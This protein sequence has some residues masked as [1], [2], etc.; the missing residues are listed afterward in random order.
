MIKLEAINFH[1]TQKNF[2]P[3]VDEKDGTIGSTSFQQ[4]IFLKIGAKIMIIHNIDTI[5]SLTNG[6]IGTLEDT[7]KSEEG[8]VEKLKRSKLKSI[9][10]S[11]C[12]TMY[13]IKSA[14]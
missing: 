12:D 8:N 6:Q 10:N 1:Q 13:T 7:I 2:K 3:K 9:R 11:C 4:R 5:D 14:K